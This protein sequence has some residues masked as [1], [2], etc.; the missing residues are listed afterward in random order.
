MRTLQINHL[1]VLVSVV[2]LSGFGA[3]WYGPLM[4]DTWMNLVGL[5][6]ATL[7]ANPP[8]AGVW[9]TNFVSTIIPVYVLAWLFTQMNVETL[10]K[11]ALIGLVIGF[12]FIHLRMMNGNMWAMRPYGL[13]WVDGGSNM[14][15]MTIAGA[16]LGAWRKYGVSNS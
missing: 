6:M 3:L 7:D 10:A 2:V 8:G 14:I 15:S 12:A 5:D 13:S 16:I 9:I 4:G 11:G 1:A